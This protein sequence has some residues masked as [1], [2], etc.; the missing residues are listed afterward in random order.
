MPGTD[1]HPN[2]ASSVSAWTGVNPAKSAVQS[3]IILFNL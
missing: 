2:R 1:R 3:R